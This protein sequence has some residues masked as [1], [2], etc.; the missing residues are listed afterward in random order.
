MESDAEMSSAELDEM[1]PNTSNLLAAL[2]PQNLDLAE[3]IPAFPPLPAFNLD[4]ICD[5]MLF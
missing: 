4:L 5:I 3:P 1:E 2:G